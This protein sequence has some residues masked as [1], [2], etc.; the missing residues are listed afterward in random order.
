[1]D[2]TSLEGIEEIE[3][4]T[5][6][7]SQQ[8]VVFTEEVDLQGL[9]SQD[10]APSSFAHETSPTHGEEV[11]G[12]QT[13]TA[14]TIAV[15]D[16]VEQINV[17]DEGQSKDREM[18]KHIVHEGF[19]W[20]PI[21]EF[22]EDGTVGDIER[23]QSLIFRSLIYFL[24]ALLVGGFFMLGVFLLRNWVERKMEGKTSGAVAIIF[25]EF[26]AYTFPWIAAS[27]LILFFMLLYFSITCCTS[28]K[29]QHYG[30][31]FTNWQRSIVGIVVFVVFAALLAVTLVQ[32]ISS[33]DVNESF[34]RF[35]SELSRSIQQAISEVLATIHDLGFVISQLE[36]FLQ[37]FTVPASAE[38]TLTQIKTIASSVA[39]YSVDGE[40]A[41]RGGFRL[42]A[43]FSFTASQ[44]M[45]FACALGIIAALQHKPD[46]LR[47]AA[48]MC[49]LGMSIAAL[50]IGVN[51]L[52]LRVLV[53]TYD[54]A[55]AFE[56]MSMTTK[57]IT[58]AANI[59][60]PMI[61]KILSMCASDRGD[62]SFDFL[63]ASMDGGVQKLNKQLELSLNTS[64]YNFSN[65]TSAMW[66]EIEEGGAISPEVLTNYTE[67]VTTKLDKLEG[68]VAEDN[69]GYLSAVTQLT[70]EGREVNR[71]NRTDSVNVSEVVAKKNEYAA[72]Y[73]PWGDDFKMVAALRAVTQVQAA[74]TRVVDC[75][76]IRG[77]LTNSLPVLKDIIDVVEK[78]KNIGISLYL[79]LF[80]CCFCAVWGAYVL[81]RPL[82]HH[83]EK[84]SRRW[85]I[86]KASLRVHQT[87]LE[88]ELAEERKPSETWHS[89]GCSGYNILR[90][91]SQSN[92]VNT[93]MMM[94]EGGL[95]VLMQMTS[96]NSNSL[97]AYLIT[98]AF[99]CLLAPFITVPIVIVKQTWLRAALR[100]LSVILCAGAVS[101]SF[102]YNNVAVKEAHECFDAIAAKRRSDTD[103]AQQLLG[104]RTD[105]SI[106]DAAHKY[107][108]SVYATII[109]IVCCLTLLTSLVLLPFSNIIA[110]VSY[111]IP[112]SS[113]VKRY[114][115]TPEARVKRWILTGIGFFALLAVF[116]GLVLLFLTIMFPVDTKSVGGCNEIPHLCDTSLDNVV[117]G[118][119]HNAMSSAEDKFVGASHFDGIA[120]QLENGARAFSLQVYSFNSSIYLCHKYCELGKLHFETVLRDV[121]INFLDNNPNDVIVLMLQQYSKTHDLEQVFAAANA[122]SYVWAPEPAGG[123]PTSNSSFYYPKLGELIERNE[124]LIVFTDEPAGGARNTSPPPWLLFLWDFAYETNT[125]AETLSTLGCAVA[126]GFNNDTDVMSRKLAILNH[127]LV[128]PSPTPAVAAQANKPKV[129]LDRV[130]NCSAFWMSLGGKGTINFISADFW[131]VGDVSR[132]VI[133]LNG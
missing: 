9:D 58:K 128:L 35:L 48:W 77:L 18:H 15:D 112:G 126:R 64:A 33:L 50:A 26:M 70:P 27:F 51:W 124:R 90:T 65:I 25:N 101:L 38:T 32:W 10:V 74:L 86:Y 109:G 78:Q 39:Q 92:V 120:K 119:P 85:F 125:T 55:S 82:K 61:V 59:D 95:L 69:E 63:A 17:D 43:V 97:H 129:I 93:V 46:L 91:F 100:L 28:T 72:K 52:V 105:C 94:G 80:I 133:S 99:L 108:M 79:Q 84:R 98:M 12:A 41:L 31:G 34:V 104:N 8:P 131:G 44:V 115:H 60:D 16:G 116:T 36:N 110:K 5:K 103:A 22:S 57:E 40:D 47:S 4:S 122:T 75:S 127:F 88:R 123:T 71:T 1:M 83:Y 66:G 81:D 89:L 11:Q 24:V 30:R 42:F 45:L 121:F 29:M 67:Y 20:P 2:V 13:A 37:G 23:P 106:D 68:V 113:I 49:A 114:L 107:E 117:W 7:M 62:I 76:L 53:L 19:I 54:S 111:T 96:S 87:V 73:V 102:M 56:S 118:M 132:T 130:R 14:T 3:L 21:E 6:S